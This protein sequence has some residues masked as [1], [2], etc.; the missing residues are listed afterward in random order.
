MASD[1]FQF[2]A[3]QQH[4][5]RPHEFL[6]PQTPSRRW[7]HSALARWRCT[8]T[9]ARRFVPC[10][11]HWQIEVTQLALHFPMTLRNPTQRDS[12]RRRR[13]ATIPL[14]GLR[15]CLARGLPYR[16]QEVI[17]EGCPG[18]KGSRA[19]R[20][21]GACR[22]GEDSIPGVDPDI[23]PRVAALRTGAMRLLP[24]LRQACTRPADHKEPSVSVV[25][26]LPHSSDR[27]ASAS[28]GT[29]SR[30]EHRDSLPTG[31]RRID[32][33]LP[34]LRLTGTCPADHKQ[35]FMSVVP[36]LPLT[37]DAGPPRP[38]PEPP[39]GVSTA[40]PRRTTSSRSTSSCPSCSSVFSSVHNMK[41]H[42][43]RTNPGTPIVAEGLA[44]GSRNSSTV[45]PTSAS[46][47]GHYRKCQACRRAK[48]GQ[49]TSASSNDSRSASATPLLQA[50]P[51]AEPPT[52]HGRPCRTRCGNAAVLYN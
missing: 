37:E 19:H 32:V 1:S 33:L 41:A 11:F 22:C 15:Q 7:S 3:W 29:S 49:R 16:R 48:N 47:A 39:P 2:P 24:T 26:S 27:P 45:S 31:E 42:A 21:R 52:I 23:G 28:A 46:R 18:G 10:S 4:P 6:S 34:T 8:T 25:P 36:P 44:C 35:P 9:S 50:P 12:G 5:N 40:P 51:A 43:R 30:R 20:V 13:Q 14:A 17:M 38:P